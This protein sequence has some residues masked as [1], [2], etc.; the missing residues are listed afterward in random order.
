MEAQD[1]SPGQRNYLFTYRREVR[2]ERLLELFESKRMFSGLGELAGGV[3]VEDVTS[4]VEEG[5][6]ETAEV[7]KRAL[8]PGQLQPVVSIGPGIGEGAIDDLT[9]AREVFLDPAFHPVE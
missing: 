5:L 9:R 1:R 8:H 2:A 6:L 3:R 4:D 7:E